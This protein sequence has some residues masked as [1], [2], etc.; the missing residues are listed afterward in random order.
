MNDRLTALENDIGF[1]KALAEEGRSPTLV[2]GS[3]MIAAG[4]IF[5]LA[6]LAEWAMTNRFAPRFGGWGLPGVWILAMVVFM[7]ALGLILRRLGPQ[8]LGDAA[9]RAIGLAWSSAGFAL[10]TLFVSAGIIAWRTG[11]D[12]PMMM[13]CP[14]VLSVYGLCWSVA[15]S[16]AGVG[17]MRLAAVGSFAAALITA[18]LCASPS[19]FLVYAAALVLLA[20]VPGLVMVRQAR[21]AG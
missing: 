21:A 6:S 1:L 14:I 19:L 15:A 10:F 5:G 9:N 20:L 8:K 3:I 7:V 16:L 11:S 13:L 18:L 2:G 17:W 12:A 4:V